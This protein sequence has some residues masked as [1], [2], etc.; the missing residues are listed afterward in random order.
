MKK[1][2]RFLV[3]WDSSGEGPPVAFYHVV[4]RIVDRRFVLEADQKEQLRGLSPPFKR[5]G[6]NARAL[7]PW[8]EFIYARF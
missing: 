3:P 1:P 7:R 6:R 2:R 8:K 5:K 4:T